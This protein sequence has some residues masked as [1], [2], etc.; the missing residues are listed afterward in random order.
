MY[1]YRGRFEACPECQRRNVEIGR[2]NVVD[3]FAEKMRR[4]SPYNYAFDNLIRFIDPDGMWPIDPPTKKQQG[5][6][7]G[8][9][10]GG[11]IEAS[12][13]LAGTVALSGTATGLSAPVSWVGAGAIIVAGVLGGSTEA[14]YDHFFEENESTSSRFHLSTSSSK[15]G[16]K[17]GTIY[18]V[19]GENTESR[20]P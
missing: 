18:E 17:T 4:Y 8:V 3:P 9:T 14:S 1:D 15:E 20:D 10:A 6:V 7:L 13:A 2:W 5:D 12:I 16:E 11:I 19:P